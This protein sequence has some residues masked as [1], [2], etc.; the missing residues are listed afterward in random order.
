MSGEQ[1]EKKY[2]DAELKECNDVMSGLKLS[3]PKQMDNWLKREKTLEPILNNDEKQIMKT[4]KGCGDKGLYTTTLKKILKKH[5]IPASQIKNRK[6]TYLRQ[7]ENFSKIM[8]YNRFD[9]PTFDEVQTYNDVQLTSPKAVQMM[10]IIKQLDA[11]DMKEH[12]RKYKHFIYSDVKAGGYGAKILASILQAYGYYNIVGSQAFTPKKPKKGKNKNKKSTRLIL[13]STPDEHKNNAFAVLS[14]SS[15]Y[16][17]PVTEKFKKRIVNRYNA[18]PEN[19]Y[20]EDV[21][22]IILD[23]GFKEGLDLFDVKYAHIFETQLTDADEKQAIGRA[24]RLC[25]QKGLDFKPAVGW[26]LEV[27]MYHTYMDDLLKNIHKKDF[28]N[29]SDNSLHDLIIKYSNLD[30]TAIEL[31]K[32]LNRIAPFL[33]V[34]Y[35]LTKPIHRADE[36]EFMELYETEDVVDDEI[37]DLTKSVKQSGGGKLD[38]KSYKAETKQ[39]GKKGVPKGYYK[40]IKGIKCSGKCG[41]RPTKDIPITI[42]QFRATYDALI[43]RKKIPNVEIPK[44]KQREFFC[45][46]ML[47]KPVF[48]NALIRKWSLKFVEDMDKKPIGKKVKTNKPDKKLIDYEILEYS[49]EKKKSLE[50]SIKKEISVHPTK[51]SD[52]PSNVLNTPTKLMNVGLPPSKKLKFKQM[53]DYVKTNFIDF[54]WNDLKVENGCLVKF[55]AQKGD[56]QLPEKEQQLKKVITFTPTQNFIRHFFQPSSAYKGMLLW[57]SVGTG[58]TCSAIAT[59]STSFEREDYNIMYVTRTTLKGDVWKNIFGLICHDIIRQEIRNGVLLPKNVDG[60]K[61]Q[62]YKR[63]LKPLSYKQFSNMLLG[64]N[65]YYKEMLKRNGEKDILKKTLIIID[66]AHKLYSSDMKAAEKPDLDVMDK[67]I[68]ESYKNSG[69]DSCRLLLMT[70]TPFTDSPLELF[71]ITNMMKENK[72]EMIPTDMA[73]FKKE[74]INEKTNLLSKSGMKKLVNKMTGYIS[75]LDRGRDATQFTQV[76]KIDVPVLMSSYEVIETID[77]LDKYN[78]ATTAKK[79]AILILSNLMSGKTNSIEKQK[80]MNEKKLLKENIREHK[81]VLREKIKECR[82][83]AKEKIKECREKY[84]GKDNREN[85]VECKNSI[86][87]KLDEDIILHKQE[88]EKLVTELELQVEEINDKIKTS[89]VS[90]LNKVKKLTKNDLSQYNVLLSKSINAYDIFKN[91]DI[92]YLKQYI[93]N[94]DKTKSG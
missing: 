58:K 67:L 63:W 53:R 9:K 34:D 80:L 81:K 49:G 83:K 79:K 3:T 91:K 76:K 88:T 15:I 56:S 20:G 18:R 14:S 42:K 35:E 64:K 52:N 6:M 62:L 87:D 92:E 72:D 66:E 41:K 22:I 45:K 16:D 60:R 37:K 55:G 59:A 24:T 50:A 17:N 1:L 69:N 78:E 77:K 94:L 71:Q 32:Q 13:H 33:A 27:Y 73:T 31:G 75:Y 7:V 68:R 84:P 12:G 26:E 21:R 74:Y 40:A 36:A 38:I 8:R 4:A 93:D 19:V 25:G 86:Q 47:S 85:F 10:E 5:T 82:E 65:D 2:T 90:L 28:D 43:K 89:S 23:S 11:K 51:H 54:K 48:C 39:I 57:H 29:I 61:R 46:E 30:K 44:T 70:A